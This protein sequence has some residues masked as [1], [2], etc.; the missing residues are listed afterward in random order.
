MSKEKNID[1]TQTANDGN[2]V[3][4]DSSPLS[5]K[6]QRFIEWISWYDEW[7]WSS[8]ANLW[9]RDGYRSRTTQQLFEYYLKRE[10]KR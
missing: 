5:D 8:V 2:T 10:R 1:T 6:Q 3:L 4:A 7:R 9:I